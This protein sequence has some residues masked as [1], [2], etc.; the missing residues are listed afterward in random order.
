MPHQVSSVVEWVVDSCRSVLIP[1]LATLCG[2]AAVFC[3][4]SSRHTLNIE[5]QH[6]SVDVGTFLEIETFLDQI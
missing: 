3:E 4:V 6:D 2:L 5:I 1:N